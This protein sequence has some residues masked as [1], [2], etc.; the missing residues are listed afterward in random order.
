MADEK[1]RTGIDIIGDM[2]WGTHFC[3]FYKTKEDLLSILVP[4]FKAGLEN[5]EFCMWITADPLNAK[6]AIT[7]LK[8]EVKDLDAYIQKGQIEILDYKEWYTKSGKFEADPVL[9]AWIEKEKMAIK[10]GFDGLR[11]TG[12]T[13][14]L[15]R[16]DWKKF[17]DYEMAINDAIGKYKM[18][19]V[20]TYSLDKCDASDVLDVVSSHE[21]ALIK[22]ENNWERIESYALK[23]KRETLH[24]NEVLRSV[25]L[26]NQLVLNE[27]DQNA[28][29]SKA[30]NA[31]LQTRGYCMAWIGLTEE[32]SKRVVPAASAGKHTD[33]LNDI[34]VTWD[35]SP[36]GCGPTGMAIKTR[37]PSVCK[38]MATDP[39]FVPWRKEAL[40]RG[41]ASSAVV[42]MF[43]GGRVFGALSVYSEVP[44]YFSEEEVALLVELGN[45]I[46]LAMHNLGL[47]KL[48]REAEEA[49][50]KSSVSLA[51][52]Q[53]IA[54]IGNWELD[55][56]TYKL[57][58]SDEIFQIFEID[59]AY[60]GATYEA[61]LAAIHP[62][63]RNAV[64]A[65]YAQS[66][67]T[68]EPYEI[69][70]R[71]LMPDGRIKYVHEQCET[72]YSPEGKPLRSVGTVQDLTAIKKIE[73]KMQESESKFAAAFN[74][75]PDLIAI[76]RASD[77]MILDVNEGFTR[78][79]G[80]TRAESVGKIT[81]E[82]SIWENPADRSRFV[83]TLEKIGQ[84]ANFETTLRRKDGTLITVLDSAK[85]L[86]L[87]GEVCILSTA[88]NITDR[89]QIE[90]EREQFFKFFQLSPDM[91]AIA[92]P[93]GCFK[94]INP[95]CIQLLGFS[96]AEL[97]D[98]PFVD[99]V[100]PDDRQSTLD[101]M[102]RQ[103]KTGYSLDFENRYMCKDGT[104]RWLSWR[105]I[106]DKDK[107]VTYATARDI[108]EHKLAEIEIQESEEYFRSIFE[109]ATD[110]I[111]IVDLESN[112]FSMGNRSICLQLGYSS[113]DIKKIGMA[114]I[115]PEKDLDHVLNL[116][117]KQTRG[118]M[119]LAENIPIKRKDGTVFYADVNS[120]ILNISGKKFLMGFFRDITERK[121]SEEKE[122]R[123]MVELVR[124]EKMDEMKNM[125][126]ASM[127][128]ELR[129]PLNSII[130]F[131]GIL[132]MGLTGELNEEQKKQ[133]GM[134]KTSSYHLLELINDV[135]DVSKIDANMINFAND[136]F[137][138]EEI[139]AE[140]RDSVANAAK[141]KGLEVAIA[142]S[143]GLTMK[144]DRRR[145]KQII[146]NLLSNAVKFTDRG[147]I[148]VEA[149]R[150]N[151]NVK[152][153]VIDSGIGI[154]DDDM[155]KLFKQ[156]SRIIT[157]GRAIQEGSGLGLYLSQ[158]IAGM[159]G[160]E[161]TAQSEFEK[162]SVF[163]LNLP[164]GI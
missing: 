127:S 91:M 74:S 77:G 8:K 117:E 152:V 129:T 97:L 139:I 44:D 141:E 64:N 113:D 5:N 58:W 29:L 49:L 28:F 78:L 136:E 10:N 22:K 46:A 65:A 2:P 148:T 160:G 161:I 26:I 138:V 86:D 100:H 106:Y 114:D 6:D 56:L 13:F 21:F 23:L 111:L 60:F 156:F 66:L 17:A 53:R 155:A 159:L 158:K 153:K 39:N 33:Y 47:E 51:E 157:P 1:R 146:L 63:D 35:E 163:V 110:G 90:L 151:G 123:A 73:W 59:K 85:K 3:Q 105:A 149:V 40:K 80:Y 118:E 19:A 130:G 36:T 71:L 62:E 96:E 32:G 140:A 134:I 92:D 101:E 67:K 30:C 82:L 83:A 41:F 52:A 162:G 69:S 154:K 121:Q 75:S 88:R 57:T 95:S 31:L 27:N 89:K 24:L 34:V 12:N 11:L 131:T 81:S 99:F 164:L 108:T 122:V 38:N 45:D 145:V 37:Q 70:H 20:C 94:K 54:H 132:L 103:I 115:H 50:R 16:K 107:G 72:Y 137:K 4:Y 109:T 112:K 143:A 133:L 147:K 87:Q 43:Y 76:T 84:V 128:H 124:A 116:F 135:I 144:N 18:L 120:S 55:L 15:E 98:K 93:N 119:T 102:S 25:S 150:E 14:W 61:F 68:H 42:P 79:L 126:I 7:G 104:S 9:K 142:V 48:H 125:F